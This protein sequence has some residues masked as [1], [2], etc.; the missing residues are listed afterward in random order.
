LLRSSAAA[1]A[2]R[3]TWA[4]YSARIHPNSLLKATKTEA[5]HHNT[6][7]ATD[8]EEACTQGSQTTGAEEAAGSLRKFSYSS[9][10]HPLTDLEPIAD[11][12]AGVADWYKLAEAGKITPIATDE[13]HKTGGA[14][15]LIFSQPTILVPLSTPTERAESIALNSGLPFE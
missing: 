15:R 9:K 12:T 3:A 1:W 7:A 8:V 5:S 13:T 2:G 11:S 10:G 4:E 14:D 6:I